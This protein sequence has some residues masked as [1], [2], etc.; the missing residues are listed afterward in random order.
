[1]LKI[2][3]YSTIINKQHVIYW[4]KYKQIAKKNQKMI[5]GKKMHNP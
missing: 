2:H 1:M 3:I 5:L 4:G